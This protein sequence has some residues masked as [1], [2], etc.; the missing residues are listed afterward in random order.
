MITGEIDVLPSD[1]QQLESRPPAPQL[2]DSPPPNLKEIPE[3][4]DTPGS[5]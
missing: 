5:C 3:E 4:P 2:S 1:Q